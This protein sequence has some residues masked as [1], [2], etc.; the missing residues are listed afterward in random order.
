MSIGQQA[1]ALNSKCGQ[2]L[3][4]SRRRRL[5]TDLFV[6]LSHGDFDTF[7]NDVKNLCVLSVSL[8][9]YETKVLGFWL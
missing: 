1:P 6:L 4:E 3:V 2:R 7:I 5:N 9:K 8:W